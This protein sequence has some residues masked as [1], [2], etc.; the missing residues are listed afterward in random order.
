MRRAPDNEVVKRLKELCSLSDEEINEVARAGR[1][2]RVPASWSLIWEKTPADNAYLILEGEVSIRRDK[3]EIATLS[4]GDFIGEMAIVDRKLRNASVVTTTE[5]TVLNFPYDDV[6]DLSARIPGFDEALRA[7]A[8][9]R[10][11]AD[12][13][14]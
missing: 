10:L 12:P 9:E 5:V 7:S 3:E 2:V 14:K 6:R 11:G 8:A 4:A 1:A 13:A